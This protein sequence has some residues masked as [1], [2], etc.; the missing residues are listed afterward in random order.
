MLAIST[1]GIGMMDVSANNLKTKAKNDSGAGD[2]FSTLMNMSVPDTKEVPLNEQ[3]PAAESK[4]NCKYDDSLKVSDS[5]YEKYAKTKDKSID[6]SSSIKSQDC[7]KF[8]QKLKNIL[9]ENMG[10]EDS[11]IEETL[12]ALNLSIEDLFDPSIFK[13]FIMDV[14]QISDVDML[15]NEEIS[16]FV[17]DMMNMLDSLLKSIEEISTDLDFSDVNDIK[18]FIDYLKASNTE[19]SDEQ[20][21]DVFCVGQTEEVLG[22]TEVTKSETETKNI[23]SDVT[24]DTQNADI[25]VSEINVS[26][27][28][29][30][31]SS[32]HSFDESASHI[33]GEINRALEEISDGV[34]EVSTFDADIREAD[35]IRQIIDYIRVNVSKD[36]TSLEMQLNPASLGKV[37][38]NIASKNGVM[39]AQIIAES[40]TAKH[41]IET[42]IQAL[43]EAFENRELKVE[44][45]EVMVGSQ[46]FFS[47][48]GNQETFDEKSKDKA[49]SVTGINISDIADEDALDEETQL[50]VEIMKSKGSSV[51]YTA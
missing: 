23:Q 47:E 35:I 9:K 30:K 14:Q 26:S 6:D 36:T 42:G 25:K 15:I 11:Q 10:L 29:K 3:T 32:N 44:A 1:N 2:A 39:Q 5:K 21:V 13:Q 7:K 46:D 37:H 18:M 8:I 48:A 28:L 45:I 27:D 51:S 19:T 38:I 49:D 43:K 41:A 33:M 22:Q 50:E 20:P 40:E 24:D 17:G 4:D 16:G 31:D 12:N 34:S